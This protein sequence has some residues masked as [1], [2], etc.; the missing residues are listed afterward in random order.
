MHAVPVALH[1]D[2]CIG[3]QQ[4][5]TFSLQ[6]RLS[7]LYVVGHNT[8]IAGSCGHNSLVYF[9]NNLSHFIM[10]VSGEQGVADQH[11]CY[12]STTNPGHHLFHNL[13]LPTSLTEASQESAII[14][15][16]SLSLWW[17]HNRYIAIISNNLCSFLG[18]IHHHCWYSSRRTIFCLGL[19]L[20]FLQCSCLHQTLAQ[21]Y[22]NCSSLCKTFRLMDWWILQVGI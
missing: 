5:W 8:F 10:L 19:L 20:V 13:R 18:C 6:I 15:K 12:S 4:E 2:K 9:F 22:R 17:I 14:F 7:P 21:T 1:S 16:R 3:P 11:H